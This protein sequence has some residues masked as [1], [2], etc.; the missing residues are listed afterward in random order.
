MAEKSGVKTKRTERIKN[1]WAGLKA[2]FSRIIWPT[3]TTIITQTIVVIIITAIV[4]VL[5]TGI[6]NVVQIVLDNIIK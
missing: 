1:W 2:E 6:D 3:K 5:I 4:G